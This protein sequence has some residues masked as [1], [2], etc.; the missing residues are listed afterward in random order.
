MEAGAV[1]G[2]FVVMVLS[3]YLAQ[4][5]FFGGK[6]N[7][8]ISDT[9]PTFITPD[10]LTFAVW[11]MI[12]IFLL[13]TVAT[14]VFPN[15]LVEL[16]LASTCPMTGLDARARLV[17]AFL[18]NA[19]WLP[20][21]NNEYFW[22]ALA[23]MVVYLS[24]L[25]SYYYSYTKFTNEAGIQLLSIESLQL[26]NVGVGVSMNASWL[27]VA[28]VVSCFFCLGEVGWKDGYGVA[29]SPA[30]AMA[31]IVS[32]AMLAL[33]VGIFRYG[34]AWV[35][36][37]AWALRG[38]YR[39]QTYPDKVRFPLL[40]LNRTIA[41]CARLCSW[42]VLILGLALPVIFHFCNIQIS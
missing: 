37:A 32:V 12:Y 1:V 14:Q 8:V 20:L 4:K 23:V 36:V 16:F 2:A 9:H 7:K 11:G 25:L 33:Y 38:I 39:M 29:G 24:F 40:A 26:A 34:L 35:C 30:S 28:F 21:F 10:G 17:A 3:N 18:A 22:S 27:L 19:I 42:T 31:V 41:D 13:V 6:D 15:P 5:K